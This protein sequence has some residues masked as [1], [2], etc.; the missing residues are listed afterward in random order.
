MKAPTAMSE[1]THDPC[2]LVSDG[3]ALGPSNSG[4]AGEL[5][6]ITVPP[7]KT[8]IVTKT[9]GMVMYRRSCDT[10]AKHY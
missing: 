8:T 1:P 4:K 3:E 6:P 2:S 9:N 5:Q 7:E 10:H